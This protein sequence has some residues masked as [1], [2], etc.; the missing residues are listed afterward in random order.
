MQAGERL[1]DSAPCFP[2]TRAARLFVFPLPAPVPS[3]PFIIHNPSAERV[4]AGYRRGDKIPFL[5]DF[6]RRFAPLQPHFPLPQSI[7]LS[8]G[9]VP[10]SVESMAPQP[11]PAAA[12][13]PTERDFFPF[14]PSSSFL[15]LLFST[16]ANFCV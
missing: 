5:S 12:S 9:C 2:D 8:R 4:F 14:S 7:H 1:S 6:C 10:K 11:P 13:R 3:P 15:L 16:V